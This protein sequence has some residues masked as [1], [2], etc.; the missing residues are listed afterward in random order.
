MVSVRVARLLAGR[1]VAICLDRPFTESWVIGLDDAERL[2]R[3]L[4]EALGGL[5]RPEPEPE[6]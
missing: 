4:G 5:V 3:D 1:Q 2:H 6:G